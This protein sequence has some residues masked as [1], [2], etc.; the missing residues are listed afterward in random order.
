MVQDEPHISEDPQAAGA[1]RCSLYPSTED[2]L[3]MAKPDIS[4]KEEFV[5]IF[6][7]KGQMLSD[8]IFWDCNLRILGF[9]L[10]RI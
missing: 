10:F 8:I 9:Y 7:T 5:W 6:N 4:E 2:R 3:V 1:D